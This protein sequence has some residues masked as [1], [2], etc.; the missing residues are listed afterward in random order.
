MLELHCFAACLARLS[1]PFEMDSFNMSSASDSD[2]ESLEHDVNYV[3]KLQEVGEN[4]FFGIRYA[5]RAEGPDL[6]VWGYFIESCSVQRPT[7]SSTVH[8]T[9]CQDKVVVAVGEEPQDDIIKGDFL[10]GTIKETHLT[11]SLYNLEP[12]CHHS[13][14]AK[15][16]IEKGG[17][18]GP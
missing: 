12:I 13:S 4:L 11:L 15:S 2:C 5:H 14:R 7:G 10:S 18:V 8:V 16:F 1:R 9:L 17:T 3:M 6:F